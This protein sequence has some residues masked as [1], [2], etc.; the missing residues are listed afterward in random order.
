MLLETNAVTIKF[1]STA[2]AKENISWINQGLVNKGKMLPLTVKGIYHLVKEY[3][4]AN[5]C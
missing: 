1:K 5:P 3:Q 4:P 2:Q